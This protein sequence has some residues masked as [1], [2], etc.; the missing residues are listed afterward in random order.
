MGANS[1]NRRRGL[2]TLHGIRLES[3]TGRLKAL[4]VQHIS[5]GPIID[6]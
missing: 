4:I 5:S 6:I 2:D 1:F 3:S